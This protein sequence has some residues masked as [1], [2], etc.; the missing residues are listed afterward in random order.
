MSPQKS[1]VGQGRANEGQLTALPDVRHDPLQRP[2]H[3][4]RSGLLLLV[5]G[6]TAALQPFP[7]AVGLIA[8]RVDMDRVLTGRSQ[9]RI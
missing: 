9:A 4:L 1:L 8:W 3:R 6:G 2:P 7:E 5:I